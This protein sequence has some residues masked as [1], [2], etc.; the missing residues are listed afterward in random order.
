MTVCDPDYDP[1]CGFTDNEI[2]DEIERQLFTMALEKERKRKTHVVGTVRAPKKN[3]PKDVM[4][5][6]LRRGEVVSRE[7]DQG[8]VILK[9]KDVRDVR[10]L[11]TKHKPSLVEVTRRTR[12]EEEAAC[13]SNT[14]STKRTRANEKP[15]AV[16]AYNKGKSGIDLE[17]VF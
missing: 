13:S 16:I 3:F 8:I 17:G 1:F 15:E 6:K 10:I 9:W 4:D 12:T 2:D 14:H 7:N 5:A 11:S